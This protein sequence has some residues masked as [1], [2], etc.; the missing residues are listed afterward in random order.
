[1]CSLNENKPLLY[2]ILGSFGLVVV[3]VTGIMPDVAQGFSIVPFPEEV[4]F[5]DAH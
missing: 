5:R 4:R 2:S 1:M 3:L